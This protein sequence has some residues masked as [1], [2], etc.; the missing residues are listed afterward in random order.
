MKNIRLPASG[1]DAAIDDALRELMGLAEPPIVHEAQ[2]LGEAFFRRESLKRGVTRAIFVEG[3][4]PLWVAPS[5]V[6]RS[7]LRY[8]W[9]VAPGVSEPQPLV[10]VNTRVEA[11]RREAM[12]RLSDPPPLFTASAWA[13]AT[14]AALA[15]MAYLASQRFPRK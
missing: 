2:E 12:N 7:P 10:I 15:P 14:G 11:E 5:F 6:E 3:G 9:A 8:D 13:V 1:E 4:G